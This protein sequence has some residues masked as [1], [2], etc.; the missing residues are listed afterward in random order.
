MMRESQGYYS[1]VQYA[2]FPERAEYVN[3]GVVLFADAR[4]YV[5][6]KFSESARRAERAFNVHLGNHF[7][8]LQAS[9]KS[10]LRVEFG[11]GWNKESI[12]KFASM[13]SGKIRLS[14]LRSVLSREPEEVLDGLFERLVGDVPRMK[15]GRRPSSKV[16]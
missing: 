11:E 14:P 3:I 2:E 16:A 10:R 15:R 8:H 7:R 9:M 12:E 5:F 1:L 13:R 6:I 4:P